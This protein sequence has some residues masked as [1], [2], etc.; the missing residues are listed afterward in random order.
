MQ[1]MQLT[2]RTPEGTHYD[3]PASCVSGAS[4]EGELQIYPGHALMTAAIDFSQ[5]VVERGD[6]QE[7]FLLKQGVLHTDPATDRTDI[8]V[9][10]C[11]KMEEVDMKTLREYHDFILEKL[12]AHES[13]GTHHATFLHESRMAVEKQM[14]K[15]R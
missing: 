8:L 3:G 1:E 9:L 11:Q 4:E 12:K 13:L 5:A 6:H 10:Y 7:R 2:I 15:M 14:E